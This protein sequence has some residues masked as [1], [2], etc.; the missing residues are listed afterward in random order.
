MT[1]TGTTAGPAGA[2]AGSHVPAPP[3]PP[4]RR[5]RTTVTLGPFLVALTEEDRRAGRPTVV[6]ALAYLAPDD[7]RHVPAAA[8][9]VQDRLGQVLGAV[10]LTDLN[11]LVEALFDALAAPR[12]PVGGG[13]TIEHGV[14][15]VQVTVSL[16]PRD[17]PGD[18]IR[19]MATVSVADPDLALPGAP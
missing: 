2:A 11:S 13:A 3:Q 18:R 4:R 19:P 16:L 14:R 9:L 12:W 1:S 17:Q 5:T 8:R 6:V 7:R 15:V 10:P